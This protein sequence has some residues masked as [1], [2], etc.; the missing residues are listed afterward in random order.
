VLL[1]LEAGAVAGVC[2]A[3]DRNFQNLFAAHLVSFAG[4]PPLALWLFAA[5][6]IVL[7]VRY[8][9]RQ[10]PVEAGLFWSLAAALLAFRAGATGMLAAAY[11]AAGGLVLVL[12]LVESSHFMAYHDELTGLPARR[13]LNDALAATEGQFCVAVVDVDHFKKFND[14]YGHEVGDQVL[15]MVASR[16]ARVTGGGHSF[17]AGGEEFCVVFRD[18]TV[19]DVLPHLDLLRE[20]IETSSF[21]VRGDDR[22]SRTAED[23]RSRK[24]AGDVE[25]SVTVSIGTAQATPQLAAVGDVLQAADEALYHAKD[26][27]RNRVEVYRPPRRRGS[28]VAVESL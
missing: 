22:V 6:L 27:G 9:M 12:A 13:A 17:R 19:R 23:R 18:C 3:D 11:F 28:A 5:T 8:A 15:R 20:T 24:S 25:I 21:I 26:A 10:R 4:V 14:T 2:G 1:A 16:L 7:V